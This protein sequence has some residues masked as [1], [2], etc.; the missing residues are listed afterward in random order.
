[1]ETGEQCDYKGCNTEATTKGYVLGHKRGSGDK[2]SLHL[3][4]AC[5]GHKNSDGF[6]EDIGCMANIK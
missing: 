4:N 3:V 2:D 1:M 6:F 5:D